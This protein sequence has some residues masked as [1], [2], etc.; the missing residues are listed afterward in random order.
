MLHQ[1]SFSEGVTIF[2]DVFTSQLSSLT[3]CDWKVELN[4]L[5][6]SPFFDSPPLSVHLIETPL[7]ERKAGEST[8]VLAKA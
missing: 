4:G 2:K 1:I 5:S 8:I 7:C 3:M 6:S